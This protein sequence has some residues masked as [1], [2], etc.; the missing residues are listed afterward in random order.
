MTNL[1]KSRFAASIDPKCGRCDTG[2]IENMAHI[3]VRCPGTKNMQ[4]KQ[5]QK[6]CEMIKEAIAMAIPRGVVEAVEVYKN[7]KVG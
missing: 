7:Q 3:M 6:V 4:I 1:F 2:E 5:H